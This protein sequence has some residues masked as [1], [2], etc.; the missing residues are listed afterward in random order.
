[1]IIDKHLSD[2]EGASREENEENRISRRRAQSAGTNSNPPPL[3]LFL[4][5]IFDAKNNIN[6]CRS[7]RQMGANHGQKE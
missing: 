7:W 4:S 6:L 2:D 1:V 3:F 5:F